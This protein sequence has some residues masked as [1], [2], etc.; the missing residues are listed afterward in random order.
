M[1]P[2]KGLE[3]PHPCEYMD[4]NHARLPIPPRWQSNL[5]SS[6]S[7]KAAE[8]GR[9]TLP[10]YR[11]PTA[12][13]TC[14]GTKQPLSSRHAHVGTAAPGCPVERSSPASCRHVKDLGNIDR[15]REPE[16]RSPKNKAG[17]PQLR[18]HRNFRIQHLRHRTSLL[19][20]L[21][22]L[23]ESCRIR[24][25]NFPHHINMARRDRPP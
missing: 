24:P 5:L 7:P 9:P 8:S 16:A 4:L 21:R 23:L 19:R 11:R 12:C 1:V 10:F 22:I 6:G 18:R 13:Q 14:D 20:R 17:L 25:R 15:K 3:P 2:S